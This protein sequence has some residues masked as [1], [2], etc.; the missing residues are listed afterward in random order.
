M[1]RWDVLAAVLGVVTLVWGSAFLGWRWARGR[2]GLDTPD[3]S[4]MGQRERSARRSLRALLAFDFLLWWPLSIPMGVL[5]TVVSIIER[6]GYEVAAG[7]VLG[8]VAFT[9]PVPVLIRMVRQLEQQRLA[10]QPDAVPPS[11]FIE[12]GQALLSRQRPP[13][14]RWAGYATIVVLVVAGI[15]NWEMT[16]AFVFYAT[17]FGAAR[18][19]WIWLTRRNA[20]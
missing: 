18:L 1:V 10:G 4:D 9:V 15:V 7:M 2:L 6:S 17:I 11:F 8:L 19:G 14:A 12:G 20:H 3:A 13:W 16:L 5:A